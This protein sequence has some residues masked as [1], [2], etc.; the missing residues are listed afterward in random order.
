MSKETF[1]WFTTRETPHLETKPL[2]QQTRD[3]HGEGIEIKNAKIQGPAVQGS[4]CGLRQLL[5]IL[6]CPR[7]ESGWGSYCCQVPSK[8]GRG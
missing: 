1:L 5:S 6:R 8:Q 4:S 3:H 7:R 2:A